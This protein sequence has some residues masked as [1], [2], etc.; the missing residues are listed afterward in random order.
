MANWFVYDANNNKRGPFSNTQLKKLADSNK[1][2]PETIIETE[3]GRKAKAA[4]V[5]GLFVERTNQGNTAP[6][7]TQKTPPERTWFYYDVVGIKCGPVNSSQLKKL[8][9]ANSI[10]GETI[11]ENHTGRQQKAGNI[12]GLFPEP[13]PAASPRPELSPFATYNQGDSQIFGENDAGYGYSDAYSLEG[14]NYSDSQAYPIE[15][16]GRTPAPGEGYCTNCGEIVSLRAAA[17]LKCGAD[18]KKQKNYCR[19]CGTKLNPEQVICLN[20]GVSVKGNN[21]ERPRRRKSTTREKNKSKV[22][23]GLLALFFGT[24]GIHKFYL[25]KPGMGV[26]YLILTLL[27]LGAIITSILSLIDAIVLFCMDD[28]VFYDTYCIEVSRPSR[29]RDYDDE[30]DHNKPAKNRLLAALLALFFGCLGVHKFYLG[31]PAAGVLYIFLTILTA[32]ILSAILSFIDFIVLLCMDDDRFG[33]K[34][35]SGW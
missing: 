21:E 15:P 6:P 30:Y 4:K 17:C 19:K 22:T 35:N 9:A 33:V 27:V 13:A 34:Y 1:I 18:P 24:L 10:N 14:M 12:K 29:Q 5:K 7:Q 3:T 25:G 20:C 28:D 23:A 8:A 26:L 2:N 16:V 32:F 31:R 11:I